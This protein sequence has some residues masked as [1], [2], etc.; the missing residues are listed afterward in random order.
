M[1]SK[2]QVTVAVRGICC[3]RRPV[4]ENGIIEQETE[5]CEVEVS[6]TDR[7]TGSDVVRSGPVEGDRFYV[8][9]F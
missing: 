2:G 3:D 9:F 8:F 7:P 6:P 5:M 4:C 1:G